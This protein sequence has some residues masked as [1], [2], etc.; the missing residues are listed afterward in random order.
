MTNDQETLKGLIMRAMMLRQEQPSMYRANQAVFS[1]TESVDGAANN[2]LLAEMEAWQSEMVNI[3]CRL[4]RFDQSVEVTLPNNVKM[5][6]GM[7]G[8]MLF[9]ELAKVVRAGMKEAFRE[10]MILPVY[11]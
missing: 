9:P 4:F 2:E 11:H 7:A 1:G 10:H 8:M 5:T 3:K 6:A